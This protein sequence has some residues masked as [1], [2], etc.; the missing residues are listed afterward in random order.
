[1]EAQGQVINSAPHDSCNADA[2]SDCRY[3]PLKLLVLAIFPF[4][5][6]SFYYLQFFSI[7]FS[8]LQFYFSVFFCFS[9]C[10]FFTIFLS[11]SFNSFFSSIFYFF[12]FSFFFVFSFFLLF[13]FFYLHFFSITP[14]ICSFCILFFLQHSFPFSYHL[15]FLT[16]LPVQSHSFMT[17]FFTICFFFKYHFSSLF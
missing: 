16:H 13:P 2:S 14:I 12:L 6:P 8:F 7:F 9:F 15:L 5:C 3:L 17:N 11:F 10:F 1:M 4:P